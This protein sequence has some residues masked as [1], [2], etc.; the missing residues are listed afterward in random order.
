MR[1]IGGHILFIAAYYSYEAGMLYSYTNHIINFWDGFWH[2]LINLGLFYL[3]ALVVLRSASKFP[4]NVQRLLAGVVLISIEF[5]SFLLIKY[6]LVQLFAAYQVATTNPYETYPLFLKDTIWRF[7]HVTGLS[8]GYWYAL[9][10]SQRQQE[11][12]LLEQQRLR[13]LAQQEI[14]KREFVTV[15]NAFLKSQ[16]NSHFLFNTLNFIYSS[17]QSLS[18][19]AARTIIGLSDILRYSLSTPA[20]GKVML[21]E[22]LQHIN[23]IFDVSRL[24]NPKHFHLNF[25]VSGDP[26][27]LQIIPLALI[28]LAENVLKYADLKDI[29]S[30]AEFSCIIKDSTLTVSINNKKRKNI[31]PFSYGI[32]LKNTTQRLVTAYGNQFQL[33]IDNSENQ[34]QL[35]LTLHLS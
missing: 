2:L 11:V 7:I 17:V 13:D 34:Y 27:Q 22:E 29:Q 32:G 26:D 19:E 15:E 10:A 12:L 5:F 4:S 6:V 1:T 18:K 3:N 23:A 28:T 20:D 21:S 31:S 8:F 33:K 35:K 30:P 9:N 16:I 14:T 24:K 25:S